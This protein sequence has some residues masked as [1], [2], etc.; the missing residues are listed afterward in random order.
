MT[1]GGALPAQYVPAAPCG[2]LDRGPVLLRRDGDEAESPGTGHRRHRRH[3]DGVQRRVYPYRW[4]RLLP[5]IEALSPQLHAR[6]LRF[7]EYYRL[8][9]GRSED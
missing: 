1:V 3:R 7:P 6:V 8:Q 4:A 9:M 5:W 2:V